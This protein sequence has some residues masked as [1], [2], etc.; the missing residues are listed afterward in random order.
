MSPSWKVSTRSARG[1][2]ALAR[3]IGASLS[4]GAVIALVG[5]LGAGKTT[6]VQGLA[7]GLG[8]LDPSTVLSPT[9]TLVNEYPAQSGVLVHVDFYRLENA[10]AGRALGIEEQLAR[11]DGVVAVEWAEN[12]PELIPEHAVWIRIADSGGKSRDFEITGLE[13]T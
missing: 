8:V 4:P 7:E 1:T 12:L 2:Q 5:D 9:Y 6:F 3:K 11:P 13:P 10:D